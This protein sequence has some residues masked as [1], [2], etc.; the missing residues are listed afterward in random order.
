MGWKGMVG[1]R[2]CFDTG[3]QHEDGGGGGL[4][5]CFSVYHLRLSCKRIPSYRELV[6]WMAHAN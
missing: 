3:D 4:I 5:H 2:I 6:H 1:D